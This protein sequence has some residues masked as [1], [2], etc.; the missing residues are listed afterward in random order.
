MQSLADPLPLSVAEDACGACAGGIQQP[1]G[2]SMAFQPVVD[3]DSGRIA[4]YEALVRGTGDEPAAQVLARVTA[5]NRYAFDQ[6][7]RVTA[8]ALASRLG[9]QQTG[10][11]LSINFIPG[12][13][14]RPENC[15]RA[16]LAAARR[17]R[18]PVE[19]L[20]FE[21]TENEQVTDTKKLGEIFRVYREHRF[22]TALDDFGAGFSGLSLLAAFT[23]DIVKIDMALIRGLD[24]DSRRQAIVGGIVGICRALDTK[25][26]AEGV[27]T[28]AELSAL[29]ALGLSLFQGYLFARPAF[30]RLPAVVL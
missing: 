25:V 7:C 14:Y 19:R 27:E 10:A 20:T 8:I 30:E 29:R 11:N 17:Y 21:L 5:G 12:A 23:P 16:T 28:R 26:V 3:L 2:F 4:S 15:V 24:T 13:M 22:S 6:S 18:F 9:L 1:F